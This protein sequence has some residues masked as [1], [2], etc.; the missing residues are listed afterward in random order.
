MNFND[1]KYLFLLAILYAAVC[2]NVS[3]N[4]IKLA[5]KSVTQFSWKYNDSGTDA[6]DD[7]SI[8]R[9]DLTHAQFSDGYYSLGDVSMSSH[10]R[11]K[12]AFAVK[13]IASDALKKPTGYDEVWND[14]GSG[15]DYDVKFWQPIAPSG[16]TCLGHVAVGSYSQTPD[17]DWIR[18]VKT[19]YLKAGSYTKVWDDT[20][21]GADDDAGVWQASVV[22]GDEAGLAANTFITRQSHHVGSQQFFVLDKAKIDGLGFNQGPV[23]D[24][25]WRALASQFAPRVYLHGDESFFPSSVPYHAPSS[26]PFYGDNNDITVSNNFLTT[27]LDCAICTNQTFLL[28]QNPASNDVPVYTSIIQK[29]SSNITTGGI[30]S[31]DTV[32]DIIYWMFYPYNKGKF[33]DWPPLTYA[34]TYYG[35]HVGDWEHMTVRFVNGYPYQVYLS[36]HSDGDTYMFG[37]KTLALGTQDGGFGAEVYSAEGSHGLYG[38]TGNIVYKTIVYIDLIDKTSKGIVWDTKDNIEVIV[39]QTPG[40]YAGV[41]SWMNY[42]GRWGNPQQ[43]CIDNIVDIGVCRLEDGPTGPIRKEALDPDHFSLE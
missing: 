18:C 8:W 7:L 24:D 12:L 15:G 32:T 27:P 42:Q 10:T 34:D 5:V 3:A 14:S 35:N 9:P 38:Y 22:S 20:G 28:G 36:Q 1:K 29:K 17:R 23:T 6:D 39:Y 40:Q 4:D 30:K 11:P 2:T 43:A 16:Y 37:D 21:S 33:I 19:D 26:S 13:A 31:T 25:D 41:H